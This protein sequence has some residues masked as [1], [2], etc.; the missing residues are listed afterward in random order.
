MKKRF[1]RFSSS[2]SKDSKKSGSSD[3]QAK[4]LPGSSKSSTSTE[5]FPSLPS[6]PD[7]SSDI[8]N[9]IILPNP[10]PRSSLNDQST[11]IADNSPV[12]LYPNNISNFIPISFPAQNH[13]PSDLIDPN[14]KTSYS[15][16]SNSDIRLIPSPPAIAN[17]DSNN[18]IQEPDFEP[19]IRTVLIPEKVRI[20]ENKTPSNTSNLGNIANETH[21][22]SS[23]FQDSRIM[24]FPEMSN[25]PK[26]SN[27][28]SK[29]STSYHDELEISKPSTRNRF[30]EFFYNK[31]P[32]KNTQKPTSS[33]NINK[34]KSKRNT[35]SYYSP[36]YLSSIN[37][38][39]KDGITTF[40]HS[41]VYLAHPMSTKIN[42][43]H[44]HGKSK[45]NSFINSA[46][47]NIVSPYDKRNKK[48]SYLAS[49]SHKIS[50]RSRNL[51]ASFLTLSK[52]DQSIS[53]NEINEFFSHLDN[54]K[55][56]ISSPPNSPVV[57][58]TLQDSHNS[59]LSIISENKINP[60]PPNNP[61]KSNSS[62]K[63]Y[64]DESDLD[65]N[66]SLQTPS[67]IG[68]FSGNLDSLNSLKRDN[69]REAAIPDHVSE[70]KNLPYRSTPCKFC[71]NK[72]PDH[73]H[74]CP[75]CSF[76]PNKTSPSDSRSSSFL[77]KLSKPS[78]SYV[79]NTR[80]RSVSNNS[81]DSF[82]NWTFNNDVTNTNDIQDNYKGFL[83][84]R[85]ISIS[86]KSSYQPSYKFN[87]S[88][89]SINPNQSQTHSFADKNSEFAFSESNKSK[90]FNPKTENLL[91][92]TIS[93]P[94]LFEVSVVKDITDTNNI[95]S[96]DFTQ[97]IFTAKK[98]KFSDSVYTKFLELSRIRKLRHYSNCISNLDFKLKKSSLKNLWVFWGSGLFNSD[99]NSPKY[100]DTKINLP[101]ESSAKNISLSSL[102]INQTPKN[103]NGITSNQL[104]ISSKAG[105]RQ[106]TDIPYLANFINSAIN[107][108][109]KIHKS[110][111]P[112]FTSKKTN[113]YISPSNNNISYIPYRNK[114][115]S[116]KLSQL[117][118]KQNFSDLSDSNSNNST[119]AK[120]RNSS[121][122]SLPFNKTIHLLDRP[123]VFSRPPSLCTEVHK[124]F[125]IGS[126]ISKKSNRDSID[127]NVKNFCGKKIKENFY[128]SSSGATS[129]VALYETTNYLDNMSSF[130]DSIDE[131]W[132]DSVDISTDHDP[133][134]RSN[135]VF[136]ST[137]ISDNEA[138]PSVKPS[139]FY[140]S[141][142]VYD[143]DDI[144]FIYKKSLDSDLPESI[145]NSFSSS[146]D[147][148]SI[149]HLSDDKAYIN[150]THS[151][152]ES[153]L[154][155]S[156]N[157]SI[158]SSIQSNRPNNLIEKSFIS[159]SR[160]S[161]IKGQTCSNLKIDT[162]NVPTTHR[163][164]SSFVEKKSEISSGLKHNFPETLADCSS[165]SS[166]KKKEIDQL[167]S[168]SS[169]K[170]DS[171]ILD[172]SLLKKN[173][174]QNNNTSLNYYSPNSTTNNSG[175]KYLQTPS[176]SSSF[177]KFDDTNNISHA[178]YIK[179]LVQTREY[180]KSRL[181]KAK[182]ESE[183]ELILVVNDLSEFVERGLQYINEDYWSDVD[184]NLDSD[185]YLS[186]HNSTKKKSADSSSEV[187]DKTYDSQKTPV[188][189]LGTFKSRPP[190]PPLS[191][192]TDAS[193]SAHSNQES[194]SIRRKYK[195]SKRKS[196]SYKNVLNSQANSNSESSL[197]TPKNS[198]ASNSTG[199]KSPNYAPFWSKLQNQSS[200]SRKNTSKN[201]FPAAQLRELH[202]KLGVVL[203]PKR[204][205]NFL[206]SPSK[207]QKFIDSKLDQQIFDL[208]EIRDSNF[209]IYNSPNTPEKMSISIQTLPDSSK[210]EQTTQG[211]NVSNIFG[212]E[213]SSSYSNINDVGNKNFE[214]NKFSN[215]RWSALSSDNEI[216]Y[217][218]S[219]QLSN[220][221]NLSYSSFFS[222][223]NYPSSQTDSGEKLSSTIFYK[224][225]RS[226]SKLR[227]QIANKNSTSNNESLPSKNYTSLEN[228]PNFYI[229][230]NSDSIKPVPLKSM[231]SSLILGDTKLNYEESPF[232]D[233]RIKKTGSFENSNE[234][235]F[236]NNDN[237]E[238]LSKNNSIAAEERTPINQVRSQPFSPIPKLTESIFPKNSL[239]LRNYED[240]DSRKNSIHLSKRRS[241]HSRGSSISKRSISVASHS[242][243]KAIENLIIDPSSPTFSR[244][245]P[246][247][248]RAANK[249]SARLSKKFNIN[250]ANDPNAAQ[251]DFSN[252]IQSPSHL[253]YNYEESPKNSINST[254]DGFSANP[255]NAMGMPHIT[256]DAYHLTPFLE[257]VMEL[258]NVIWKVLDAPVDSL[259]GNNSSS[260]KDPE[261]NHTDQHCDKSCNSDYN[262]QDEYTSE[263]D[264]P[265]PRK[266]NHQRLTLTD[267]WVIELQ[268]LGTLW[269][270]SGKSNINSANQSYNDF[271]FGQE[272]KSGSLY[273]DV[274]SQP[275]PC[276]GMFVRTL[277][278]ISSLNRIVSWWFA[279][280][281]TVGVEAWNEAE[282]CELTYKNSQ[283]YTNS[284]SSSFNSSSFSKPFDE[285]LKSPSTQLMLSNKTYQNN[286]NI[287]LDSLKPKNLNSTSTVYSSTSEKVRNDMNYASKHN[288]IISHS[289]SPIKE[290]FT[291]I[292]NE[293]LD[294]KSDVKLLNEPLEMKLPLI[295][296]YNSENFNSSNGQKLSID[297]NN[298][299]K[300]TPAVNLTAQA[301]IDKGASMLLEL[302]LDGIIRYISPAWIRVI[303]SDP[304]Q[305]VDQ[306]V[307]SIMDSQNK[308][309]C[310]LAIDQ[311]VSDQT[312]TV[313][314]H[315]YLK[316]YSDHKEFLK[317]GDM[318]SEQPNP[319]HYKKVLVEAKG[320][321]MYDKSINQ[322]SHVL[323]VLIHE[324]VRPPS[325]AAQS[326]QS[327]NL[328]VENVG[329]NVNPNSNQIL[330]GDTS[331]ELG[332]GVLGS[333]KSN[334]TE[335]SN[336][337][338]QFS[339]YNQPIEHFQL[340]ETLRE[341]GSQGVNAIPENFL[342]QIDSSNY[343][344]VSGIGDYTNIPS[345]NIVCR[346]CDKEID[347]NYFEQH[348]WL[349]AQSNRAAVQI[350]LQNDELS[351][352]LDFLS[353]W[354]PGC[355][356]DRLQ[357]ISHG[358]NDIDK[359][360][361]LESSKKFNNIYE[362]FLNYKK[363]NSH[364]KNL[365]D[366]ISSININPFQSYT[367]KQLLALGE[368]RTSL[369]ISCRHA[370]DL[371]L[372]DLNST[373]L[374]IDSKSS[375]YPHLGRSFNYKGNI[376]GSLLHFSDSL[377]NLSFT[378]NSESAA[379]LS[380]ASQLPE[381]EGSLN[382]T[383][384]RETTYPLTEL[385]SCSNNLNTIEKSHRWTQLC[386]LFSSIPA[387]FNSFSEDESQRLDILDP[388]L[389]KIAN[390]LLSFIKTKQR[391]IDN[392]QFSL[393]SSYKLEQNWYPHSSDD[394]SSSSSSILTNNEAEKNSQNVDKDINNDIALSKSL[395]GVNI[396]IFPESKSS[397]K[398]ILEASESSKPTSRTS[399]I[400][401]KFN[402]ASDVNSSK[403]EA[404]KLGINVE[405]GG[406]SDLPVIKPSLSLENSFFADETQKL[407]PDLSETASL[408]SKKTRPS[409]KRSSRSS[410]MIDPSGR[411][412]ITPAMPSIDDFLLL[413]PI[414]KGAYGSVYLAKKK[415]TGEYFAIKVLKK[416]DM[417]AK[418]QISNIKAERKIM[419]A[420]TDSPFV[421]KLLYTFQS[422]NYLYLVMEYLNGGDCAS[423]LK[424]LGSLSEEWTRSYLAEVVL[425]LENLHNLNIVHRD[426][427]PDNLLIDQHGHL[428]LT[429]FGLSRLGF[430]GRRENSNIPIGPS[431][432]PNPNNFS[433]T[434]EKPQLPIISEKQNANIDSQQSSEKK[435]SVLG[436]PDYLAPESILGTQFGEAVDWWALGAMC[437]E[438]LFG[439]PPFHDDT[440][441]KVFENILSSPINFY[442]EERNEEL[443]EIERMKQYNLENNIDSCLE[444]DFEPSYPYISHEAQDFITRLLERDPEKRLG[445]KGS[446]EVKSHPFFNGVDWN[447]LTSMQPAFVPSVENIEDTEYFDSRGAYLDPM[448]SEEKKYS[449]TNTNNSSI[450]DP[451]TA[452]IHNPLEIS[453]KKDVSPIISSSVDKKINSKAISNDE[454]PLN[455]I[456][457]E[458]SI[459]KNCKS[460]KIADLTKELTYQNSKDNKPDG[461][462]N[463]DIVQPISNTS[464]SE[465]SKNDEIQE[466]L[467][468]DTDEANSIESNIPKEIILDI[469]NEFISDESSEKSQQFGGFS[470]KNLPALEQENY[471][472]ILKLRRRSNLF[473]SNL[474]LK[475]NSHIFQPGYN[476]NDSLNILPESLS[477]ESPF[478]NHSSK[479]SE[480]PGINRSQTFLNSSET[481]LPSS[482]NINEESNLFFNGDS[483]I[484][485]LSRGMSYT[486]GK[487]KYGHSRQSLP[488]FINPHHNSSSK[489]ADS[490]NSSEH[491]S[492]I[493]NSSKYDSVN[494]SN[495]SNV[496]SDTE[497]SYKSQ[498]S[499]ISSLSTH[500]SEHGTYSTR[501]PKNAQD[502]NP[503]NYQIDPPSEFNILSRSNSRTSKQF[504]KEPNSKRF[505]IFYDSPSPLDFKNYQ[506]I[507]ESNSTISVNSSDSYHKLNE[508][509]DGSPINDNYIS[510]STDM[511]NSKLS[512]N[513]TSIADRSQKND[514]YS[515]SS[516]SNDTVPYGMYTGGPSEQKLQSENENNLRSNNKNSK[517]SSFSGELPLSLPSPSSTLTPTNN[518]FITS[519][520]NQAEI[521]QSPVNSE[522]N[523]INSKKISKLGKI[524][525]YDVS[526]KVP[527]LQKND[528]SLALILSRKNSNREPSL[529][530]VVT[531]R[532]LINENL[533]DNSF[534]ENQKSF[535]PAVSPLP[536]QN[537]T[538]TP[539]IKKAIN[540][541]E[542][543]DNSQ[544]K[545]LENADTP[546]QSPYIFDSLSLPSKEKGQDTLLHEFPSVISQKPGSSRPIILIA[547]DNPVIN[548][549]IETLLSR[550][551]IDTVVVRNGAEA[552]R[553]AMARTRFDMIFMDLVMP[554]LDGDQAARMIKS[555]NNSNSKTPI[556]AIVAFEGEAE[557]KI[558]GKI[559]CGENDT[560]L[561]KESLYT[562]KNQSE[563]ME[564]KTIK[565]DKND[566]LGIFDGELL[567]PINQIKLKKLLDSF[568]IL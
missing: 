464:N 554:I 188:A 424:T 259:L 36:S 332:S 243:R 81:N 247:K 24:K 414:S 156:S 451:N 422:R 538:S 131:I 74:E 543:L 403:V 330:I 124:N 11:E 273:T 562:T 546:I 385:T 158:S 445:T 320:M 492:I 100:S 225:D 452:N 524:D 404:T 323:W 175:I 316:K 335:I 484:S 163:P 306:P 189:D 184:D 558:S 429:D 294:N 450:K 283:K 509:A 264:P 423:L 293:N 99:S 35:L 67:N 291:Q 235:I 199:Y 57:F 269:E 118:F 29:E 315:F 150:N 363:K 457:N 251:K 302:S 116:K 94:S 329:F 311:L 384:N 180:I 148:P 166:L 205:P 361:I 340:F 121:N 207:D 510:D 532:Q 200:L 498:F 472:E 347:S 502:K 119:F 223:S 155:I 268:K 372:A 276:R 536:K 566:S 37:N 519:L 23:D 64:I 114:Q 427:K 312:R 446:E 77:K 555:T 215:M 219:R 387:M 542:P 26:N 336:N 559:D 507:N 60:E 338:P 68:N 167:Y 300:S 257:A 71:S 49:S 41:S 51:S 33:N 343:E 473:D 112:K 147:K 309:I 15:N 425:G 212:Y 441:E 307:E 210:A 545:V 436:T 386:K 540:L 3:K 557:Y 305:L 8:Q 242:S 485:K 97:K 468:V 244:A 103:S 295:S 104:T 206:D 391:A 31:N 236:L 154:D 110:S 246:I 317:K 475:R 277:L 440:P 170:N 245:I 229:P 248:Q 135:I 92:H 281:S 62:D 478:N 290:A 179:S 93:V 370:I 168:K 149:H 256:E 345:E 162:S 357:E 186:R 321:L 406:S 373:D 204:F 143:D 520:S 232:I 213:P 265:S 288:S 144:P 278:A 275:W 515:V 431:F 201:F 249:G 531:T 348:A 460:D 506:S 367:H 66:V 561:D 303:G 426:L 78:T 344:G 376:T 14:I 476:S 410:T 350:E 65:N 449:V 214:D 428:K 369:Q 383:L 137:S 493:N 271:S 380:S 56:P 111:I 17:Q 325:N 296:P 390:S 267:S 547:D 360:E 351:N 82:Y 438:F 13:S 529:L 313:E 187:I 565:S 84:N 339:S 198:V 517:N 89:L 85:N 378:S 27:S 421:V 458:E 417:I 140:I 400:I 196:R 221:S 322:P 535:N 98:R 217:N 197:L 371:S 388:C 467:P 442:T 299:N 541:I 353:L 183:H 549:I 171:L 202:S 5:F 270:L 530:E 516:S 182:S 447:N 255:A 138:H 513:K 444:D 101:S 136:M 505:S 34:I 40:R 234:F 470:F 208:G 263:E 382:S 9:N 10:S 463:I 69:L 76:A 2:F 209:G 194:Y 488:V 550:F 80:N 486:E 514:L 379:D 420:Q 548:K 39:P 454:L 253:N 539:K 233:S 480:F 52:N 474:S 145:S 409:I 298:Y 319:E 86:Q 54:Q 79:F 461:K 55:H 292:E 125:S 341:M 437:Y 397:P 261:I 83:A 416:S 272:E 405:D 115:H 432:G 190:L 169:F 495:N 304:A 102:N 534:S 482:S 173:I 50:H 334:L 174:N 349:C 262:E 537:I 172:G 508:N 280:K 113:S 284:A 224:N 240:S 42:S 88:S 415:S 130:N 359:D 22:S 185:N 398:I 142:F 518:N 266:M 282:K 418:N 368:I 375:S 164:K 308:R 521:N 522:G 230:E 401:D 239:K 500:I 328:S 127:E 331:T 106:D 63:F 490:N 337:Y 434:D 19:I 222:G 533:I 177:I 117:S 456:N 396:T 279:V 494:F 44:S 6:I 165:N 193:E 496:Q 141:P 392:L 90:N 176:T 346:I 419:I 132:S 47:K 563:I 105:K 544:A 160:R 128:S 7:T 134:N 528:P 412:L 324:F 477:F 58:N 108:S 326:N 365:F 53:I 254:T 362:S 28:T 553:C 364:D 393:F 314:T 21:D 377:P 274:S 471:K 356:F 439:I 287:T 568:K 161:S 556:I 481:N 122:I 286:L 342:S 499:P 260:F 459:Y 146:F 489:Q 374:D 70:N 567:K 226:Y 501:T 552:I 297:T 252:L 96:F 358:D 503:S 107:W 487:G 407:P 491:G 327:N 231:K 220:F 354:F 72:I 91:K 218:K 211:P 32:Q 318:N 527:T 512:P 402:L 526:K 73:L 191:Y 352:L 411:N 109:Y 18:P 61:I 238:S 560:Q 153:K 46:F 433:A 469:K 20:S 45:R 455:I 399:S 389:F 195:N 462:E 497:L 120:K 227:N 408:S 430:L 75:K 394:C 87:S 203:T 95:Q 465:T 139:P 237:Q 443:A 151:A 59:D 192:G 435:N 551:H 126:K 289:I 523:R 43:N 466:K 216:S 285:E 133:F 483:P 381:I 448:L 38:S 16:H 453:P 12:D 152:H 310:M 241:Y 129:S 30:S 157:T 413:K 4:E 25:Q 181:A 525:P 228:F 178:D 48:R 123:K 564:L 1:S 355:Q 366:D 159:Q 479:G 301:V 333:M 395:E 258:V 511:Y 250:S 504:G